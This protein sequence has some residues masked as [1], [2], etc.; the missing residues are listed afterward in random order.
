MAVTQRLL[1]NL[2]M[3]HPIIFT[4][5]LFKNSSKTLLTINKFGAILKKVT[6]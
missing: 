4:L 6:L 3:N 5:T 2:A 1:A